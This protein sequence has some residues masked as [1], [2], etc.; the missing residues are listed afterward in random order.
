M[1]GAVSALN[2]KIAETNTALADKAITTEEAYNALSQA[3]QDAEKSLESELTEE[4]YT[5]QI[6]ALDEAIILNRNSVEKVET[7]HQTALMY[8]EQI[9]SGSFCQS[10]RGHIGQ[11]GL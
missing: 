5:A 10:R 1:T 9:N 4:I 7:L 2:A 3:I 11:R 8:D 6:K